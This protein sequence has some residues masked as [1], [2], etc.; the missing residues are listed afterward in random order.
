MKVTI[1][2]HVGRSV[3]SERLIELGQYAVFV[4]ARQI[5]YISKAIGSKLSC[6]VRINET[7]LE[8]IKAMLSE[9]I[10][11]RVERVTQPPNVPVEVFESWE[12]EDDERSISYDDD[13]EQDE[14][15]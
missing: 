7:Q 13:D 15:D 8:R 11:W 12:N 4:D 3:V 1:K 10:G 2:S 6:I 14:L 5:G 9:L